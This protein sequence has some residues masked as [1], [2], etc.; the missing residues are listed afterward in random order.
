MDPKCLRSKVEIP[1]DTDDDGA[2]GDVA[3]NVRATEWGTRARR[4]QRRVIKKI[5]EAEEKRIREVLG[6]DEDKDI[7]EFL[8]N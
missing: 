6:D 3:D 7:E 1:D 2:G 5:L 8:E 4:R